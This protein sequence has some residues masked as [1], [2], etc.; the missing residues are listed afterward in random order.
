MDTQQLVAAYLNQIPASLHRSLRRPTDITGKT[1]PPDLVLERADDLLQ[2]LPQQLPRLTPDMALPG[3]DW[4]LEELLGIGG[5]GEVWRARNPHMPGLPPVALK[6]CL[7]TASVRSL[8]REVALLCQIQAQGKHPGIVQLLRTNLNATIPYLEYEYIE[9]SD[10]GGLVLDWQS[11]YE[12]DDED[13]MSPRHRERDAADTTRLT[14]Y[15]AAEIIIQLTE[16]VGFMHR[17]NPPIVHRDLKPS[18]ILV[19]RADNGRFLFKITDFGIGGRG[20]PQ[21]SSADTMRN[22][23]GAFSDCR[24]GSYTPH[25]AS[26]QQIKGSS[27]RSSR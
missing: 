22:L 23:Q 13:E 24:A 18:N 3:V 10:L 12:D 17:L 11:L 15:E 4:V 25:Y 5:F 14:P 6:F 9:G 1:V 16:I 7:D 26:Q 27:T 19:Q 21:H 8:K 2:L 20:D